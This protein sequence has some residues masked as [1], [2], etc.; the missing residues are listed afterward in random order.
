[1]RL[2]ICAAILGLIIG[3]DTPAAVPDDVAGWTTLS[4]PGAW[5]DVSDGRF[6]RYDGF[7][8]YRCCVSVPPT[9]KDADLELA[10]QHV[11][12]AHEAYFNGVKVGSAGSLPPQ[13]RSGLS[14]ADRFRVPSQIVLPG[15]DNV[16][17]IRVYDNDGRGGFKEGAPALLMG[18]EAIS[19][20]GKWQFR[21]GDRS[22]WANA[23]GPE[24]AVARFTNV[25]AAAA[26]AASLGSRS[27]GA[28]TPATALAT[29]TVP[30][31]LALEQ[32]LAEPVV[33]QPLVITFDERGRLWVIQYIQ[34]PHP[35]GLKEL[36]RDVFWRTQYDRVP[37][38]PPRHF[39]GE[40]KI[41]IH[42]DLDGDGRYDKHTTFVEGLSIVKGVAFGRGGVWVLNPPYLLFYPNRDRD[43]IP[44]GDPVVHLEGFG[45]EDTHSATNSLC[46]GPDG[47]LYAA[48]G[49]T[50]TAN[51]RRPGLDKKP[52]HSMGQN[53]WRYH[54]ETRRY[55]IF[56]EGGGNAH[57]V[58][59]DAKGRV[60]SGH[61]GGDTRGFHYV[62]GGY[63]QK[64]FGKH[65]PLSNPYTFGYFAAMKHHSVPRF[66]HTFVIYDADALP[67]RYHGNLFG[68]API[69]RHVV[70][71]AIEPDGSSFKTKDVGH[72]V[73]TTDPQFRPVDI[74]L[75]PDGALY[76][77]DF[78]EPYIS[79]REH[80]A[81]QIEKNTG[82]VYR[83]R[84][85]NAKPVPPFDDGKK[86][87]E[88]LVAL[89][90]H[91]NKW[92]RFSAI[93]LLADRKDTSV[94]PALQMQ[95]QTATGQ[96]A[97]DVLWAINACGGFD[98]FLA[99]KSLEH[100]DPF[101]RLWTVRL[102][103]DNC[104]VSAS[105][106][107]QMAVMASRE[108]SIE[109]R[110]QLGCTS[111]RLGAEHG[112]PIV[113]ALLARHEDVGDI[114]LPLLL[115][116]SIESKVDSDRDAVLQMFESTLTWNLPMVEQHILAR[117][118]R[119]LASS[120]T[121]KDLMTC[122]QLLRQAPDATHAK[123]LMQGFE[124]GLQGRSV[125][126]LPDELLKATSRFGGGS[127]ILGLRQGKLDAVEKALDLLG[128]DKSE[129]DQ[130]L[131]FIR[132]FGEVQQP[133]CV[134]VLLRLLERATNDALRMAILATLQHYDNA[135]IGVAVLSLYA[136]FTTDVQA[137]AQTLL[138]SRKAWSLLLLEAIDANRIDP[139]TIPVDIA[140]KITVHRDER[141]RRLVA[142]HFGAID[143][144]TSQEMQQEI[145]RL[146]G[147]LRNGTGSPY[148]GKKLFGVH[149]A[150]CH[151]L[152]GEGG[153]VGPDLT[154]FKRDDFDHMLVNIVNPS[155]EIR[156]G[157]ENLLLTTKD[158]RVV[159]GLMVDK[160][161]HVLV[162]RGADGQT[163]SIQHDEIE[164]MAPQKK[165]LMP[166]D[167]LKP[168][169]EQQVRD[170][171]AYLRST[172][173]LH[174]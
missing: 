13:Y 16:I 32:V 95:L 19:L 102:L 64:G 70:A 47:W 63:Y 98:D 134:E 10:I 117:L 81:G 116:W 42:E 2:L 162:L 73:T 148:E 108:P 173:P 75:G 66:T 97:L 151:R 136:K 38:P 109:T 133:K 147:T 161:N 132:V 156:E 129:M 5:E 18:K 44:D 14:H 69:L 167:V 126:D 165:S 88:Q 1:M 61:N 28:L 67:T 22:E 65:G 29:F 114:Y 60:Y 128:D 121:R 115:W 52:T 77:A 155:I 93:R 56:A 71:A 50:V 159:N 130:R 160:D 142:K 26:V 17:A 170:L 101:V 39:R 40:D 138:A 163:V 9:W 49:S 169:N 57:G 164:E 89:L 166:D 144:A 150:K 78:Y 72:P 53:I 103:G 110:C 123:R 31:D 45:L 120:G 62:Q 105:L 146:V 127:T 80:Y 118:M 83:L 35:A 124:E 106:A 55:E 157:Y 158:G 21:T 171:F 24:I 48:Q 96:S 104:R 25:A 82:R 15:R 154:S 112:L 141:I 172:Q 7:A 20:G 94:V 6:L 59:I 137:T 131:Q 46:W 140:R 37:P 87:T 174:Q 36:S 51:V 100:P 135:T 43:D 54:P 74:R 152:F 84:A 143:G 11:D 149:C 68:V 4:V 33:R 12:N 76:V 119:R 107:A 86:S 168:L 8:W 113:R 30:D 122:A 139:K 145:A 92:R 3:P 125:T 27:S 41:T 79:H 23:S 85:K 58:E 91:P 34:Y 90:K 111:K 153:Q 99:A